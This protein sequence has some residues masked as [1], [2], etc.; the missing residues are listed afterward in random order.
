MWIS[1][2]QAFVPHGLSCLLEYK[3]MPE[4]LRCNQGLPVDMGFNNRVIY[5]RIHVLREVNQI[6]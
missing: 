2:H 1:Y 6:C 5:Q 3:Y 4:L